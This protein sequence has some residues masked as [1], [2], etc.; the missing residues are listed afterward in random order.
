MLSETSY[1]YLRLLN[2]LNVLLVMSY[3]QPFLNDLFIYFQN[4]FHLFY[5]FFIFLIFSIKNIFI[6]NSFFLLS[7]NIHL[8]VCCVYL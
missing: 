4:M 1:L 8:G 5:R 2:G 7:L 3:S 6:G